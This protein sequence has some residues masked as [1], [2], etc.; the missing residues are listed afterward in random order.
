V[1]AG[2]EPLGAVVEGERGRLRRRRP[3]VGDRKAR[4]AAEIP[5][6]AAPH[7]AAV[8]RVA[9]LLQLEE[10]EAPADG[11]DG[12]GRHEHGVAHRQLDELEQV[13]DGAV[14]RPPGDLLGLDDVAEAQVD[15]GTG[16]RVEDHPRLGLG[17][18]GG[19]VHLHRQVLGAVEALGQQVDAAAERVRGLDHEVGEGPPGV[20]AAADRG[21]AV[22]VD[23]QVP[24]LADAGTERVAAPDALLE[25]RREEE[26][27]ERH[28]GPC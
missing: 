20:G 11:V 2:D 27:G 21:L 7:V 9:R 19:R 25:R 16:L 8:G 6:F 15:A 12:A 5:A 17:V 10:H 24:G 4:V 23:R 22:V 1:V 14:D 18:A 28:G 26:G 3:H 13:V